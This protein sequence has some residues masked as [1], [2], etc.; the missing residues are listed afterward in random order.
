MKKAY[1]LAGA[2]ALVASAALAGD[3]QS[4]CEE[5]AANNGVSAEPCACIAEAVA[6]DADLQAE[7]MAL[8]TMEDYENSSDELHAALDPCV[9]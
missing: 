4:A 5:F 3:S 8:V 6:G 1:L 9:E 2:M 7:Q